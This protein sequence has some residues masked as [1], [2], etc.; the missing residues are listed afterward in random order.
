MKR[1]LFICVLLL[2]IFSALAQEVKLIFKSQ[3]GTKNMTFEITSTIDD[4]RRQIVEFLE[5]EMN[6]N[7]QELCR[8]DEGRNNCLWNLSPSK[9]CEWDDNE[10]MWVLFCDEQYKKQINK[11]FSSFKT[12]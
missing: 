2:S 10:S 3:K 5:S 12:Y 1:T 8:D 11:I 7:I 6:F 9:E 4:A